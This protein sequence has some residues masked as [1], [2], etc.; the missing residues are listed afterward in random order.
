MGVR[1]DVVADV[2]RRGR[3]LARTFHVPF[4]DLSTR[5]ARS[6]GDDGA[7]FVQI[8]YV[9]HILDKLMLDRGEW[10]DAPK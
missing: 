6:P 10:E 1:N 2:E 5:Y 7:L 9:G 3:E 8:Q 4:E